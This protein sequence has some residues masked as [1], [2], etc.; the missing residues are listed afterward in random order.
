MQFG[1]MQFG[2]VA[3]VLAEA[4]LRKSRAKVTH[5]LVARD[6]RDHARRRD[7]Q[8]DAIALNDRSLWEWKRKHWQAIDEHMLRHRH[9][10]GDGHAH[11]LVCRAQNIEP[12]DLA[13]IDDP[14]R[15]GHVR[16]RR[17][18]DIHLFA[19][20]RRELFG[21]V[22]LSV[23]EFLRKDHRGGNHRAGER[24]ATGFIDAGDSSDAKGAQFLFVTESAAPVH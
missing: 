14:G 13:M 21:I 5:D 24:A 11:C 1:E 2:A 23:A 17:K 8:A 3:F 4:I 20:F 16:I 19:Q 9:H 10:C 15:P 12:I 18:I 6:L 22:Q 7:C